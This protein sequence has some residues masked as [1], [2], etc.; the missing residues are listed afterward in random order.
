MINSPLQIAASDYDSFGLGVCRLPALSRKNPLWVPLDIGSCSQFSTVG[1]RAA[2]FIR[3][4]AA[5]EILA[6]EESFFFSLALAR[7][8]I[9][10]SPFTIAASLRKKKLWHPGYQFNYFT[11]KLH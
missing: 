9:A 7:S 11:L 1:A 8:S 5:I 6:R 4:E 10:A 2:F 3:S